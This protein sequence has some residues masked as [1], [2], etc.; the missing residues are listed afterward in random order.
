M[1]DLPAERYT[2]R[3]LSWLQFNYRVLEEAENKA[4]PLLERLKFLAISDRNL[5]EFYMIRVAG[6]K[7][8]SWDGLEGRSF[9]GLTISEQLQAINQ[10]TRTMVAKQSKVWAEL[11]DELEK[12]EIKIIRNVNELSSQELDFLELEFI[13]NIFPTLT[14]LAI[15]PAHPF[16]LI[17]NDGLTMVLLLENR[18]KLINALIPLPKNIARFIDING[19]SKKFVA[20]EAVISHFSRQLF[21]GCHILD[22]SLFHIIRNSDIVI[23]SDIEDDDD[24]VEIYKDALKRRQHGE[25]IRLMVNE[26]SSTSLLEFICEELE[27]DKEDIFYVDDL[28]NISDLDE[29]TKIKRADLAF[30]KYKPKTP[31]VFKDFNYNYFAAIRASDIVMHHPYD[32]F[33]AVVDFLKQAAN[34]SKVIAIK[35]M[36]Y[37]TSS[38]SPIVRALAEAAENGKQVTAVIE[39][40]ARFDE[41][42]NIKLA[43]VLEKAG[44]QV[45]YGFINYKTHSKICMVV[46]RESEG[47]RT[48][49][50]FGTGNYNPQTAKIYTDLSLMSCDEKLGRDAIKVFNYL[51][52]Y[53]EPEKLERLYISPINLQKKLIK[54]IEQE[55]ENAKQGLPAEIWAKMNSLSDPQIIDELYAAAMAGVKIKLIVRGICCLNPVHESLK[56]NIEVRSIVGRFLEHSRICCFANGDKIGK[57]ATKVYIS[58]SDWMQ[59]SFYRRV[60]TLIPI[61]DLELKERICMGIMNANLK[62][63]KQAWIMKDKQSYARLSGGDFSAQEF[64]MEQNAKKLK[65][66][67]K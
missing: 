35:Q 57:E 52:G 48:Y 43:Q 67:S 59:R 15:D 18:D 47:V 40:K 45:I 30:E 62:D 39:I 28:L 49:V 4:H 16:P 17:A 32:S 36:L 19:K 1:K 21:P 41:E 11:S 34:D 9:D 38:N 22:Q 27:I 10:E 20:L 58:S 44:V 60:E 53:A 55:K 8:K 54:L 2:N 23:D 33:E 6:L 50:H 25:I 66:K 5:D 51:T 63:N 7:S 29:L 24:L 26:G 56:G 31:A 64:F 14:P 46:R 42:A 3:E 12:Q 37:R 65:K 61:K 13:N